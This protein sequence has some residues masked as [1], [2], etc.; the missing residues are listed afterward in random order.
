M[1]APLNAC[2]H[3]L[4]IVG[5]RPAELASSSFRLL[6]H[7][8]PRS[9]A[10]VCFVLESGR[11]L[12]PALNTLVEQLDAVFLRHAGVTLVGYIA[13]H[14]HVNFRFFFM[15]HLDLSVMVGCSILACQSCLPAFFACR[16]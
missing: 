4:Q 11:S 3:V 8:L 6:S 9:A 14:C 15:H 2:C 10:R 5:R 1:S 13:D 16:I 12:P 7:N